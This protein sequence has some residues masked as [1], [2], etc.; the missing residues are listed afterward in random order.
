MASSSSKQEAAVFFTI[1][2]SAMVT[3]L[4]FCQMNNCKYG[5]RLSLGG[6]VLVAS[7]INCHTS[8]TLGFLLPVPIFISCRYSS[9]RSNSFSR[10]FSRKSRPAA[11]QRT[12]LNT[13][14]G[15]SLLAEG[16]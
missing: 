15:A 12:L 8:C 9:S 11:K 16:G 5:Y 10:P 6:K 13:Q 7:S 4:D 1:S 14:I 3:F 2:P